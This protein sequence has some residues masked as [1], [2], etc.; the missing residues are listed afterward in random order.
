M[1]LTTHNISQQ[2]RPNPSYPLH[3]Y[4]PYQNK[5]KNN[6]QKTLQSINITHQIF[7]LLIPQHQQTQLKHPK[8]KKHLKNTFPPYVLLHLII[9]HQ[10]WYVVR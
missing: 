10:S 6:L 1:K 9:T 5:L 4:S 8:P 2:L 3:T 7:T